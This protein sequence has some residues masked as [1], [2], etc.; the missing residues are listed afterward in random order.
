MD[1]TGC[2]IVEHEPGKVSGQPIVVGTRIMP[3]AIVE[4]YGDGMS[5]EEIQENYPSLTP[6]QILR[7]V[8][9]AHSRHHAA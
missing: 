3:D 4:D 8:D 6:A 7:L 5:V 2:E 9:F 1:W